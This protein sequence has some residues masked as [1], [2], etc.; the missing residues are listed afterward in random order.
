MTQPSTN[1]GDYL[2]HVLDDNLVGA[3]SDNNGIVQR[4]VRVGLKRDD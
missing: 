3:F 4:A 2:T 1:V